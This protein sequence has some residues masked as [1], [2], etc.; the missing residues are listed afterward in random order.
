M[1]LKEP[2]PKKTFLTQTHA[3]WMFALLSRVDSHLSSEEMNQLRNLAR[4]CV[5]LIKDIRRNPLDYESN[6]LTTTEPVGEKSCW[7]VI[8]A[9]VD[10]WAQRDLWMDA[11]DDLSKQ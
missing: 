8:T 7:I 1:F 5:A 6:I 10:F 2:H 9:I 4:S 11:E 3:R